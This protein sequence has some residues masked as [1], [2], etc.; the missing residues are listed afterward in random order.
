LKEVPLYAFGLVEKN[1][2]KEIR[3]ALQMFVGVVV[4]C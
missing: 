4:L 3:K 2:Q 1:V